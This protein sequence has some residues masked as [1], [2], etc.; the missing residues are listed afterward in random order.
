[1]TRPPLFAPGALTWALG[2]ED[3]C[4]Y[5]SVEGGLQ[6]DEH[7]L[8][9]HSARWRDDLAAARTLGA[10]ALRYGMSWPLVHTGPG[11]FAWDHLDE[12]VDHA[13]NEL[14]LDLVADL[15]HYGTPPWL[16]LSFAD[17]LFPA[18][19]EEFAGALAAR[20]AGRI[21]AYTP[22]NEP[23]TTAS[24][25]G[26]RGVWPPHRLGWDGWVS[27]AVPIAVGMSRATDAIRRADPSALIVHVEASTAVTA[28]ADGASEAALLASVGWLPT[29]LLMG[30]VDAQHPMFAWL[31]AHGADPLALEEVRQRAAV[32][33]LL[34]V[35]YYPDLTPRRLRTVA[36]RRLQVAY[37]GGAAVF[38]DVL[39]GFSARYGLPLAV[40][41]TSIEG[42]D[43]TRAAWV[44]AAVATVSDLRDELDIRALTWWPLFDFVDW[45]WAS[46]GANVEEFAVERVAADGSIVVGFAE[47]LGSPG[48][49]KAPFLRRMGLLRLEE[50][51]DG[52]L[53]RVPTRAAAAFAR[54]AARR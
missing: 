20:Y 53:A 9:E 46:D 5:P 24:F 23:L 3:T 35:N 42:D 19:L 15:V 25:S 49:A 2:I 37:D 54:V 39:R 30:R 28:D 33:D 34:G 45:S 8:T 43:D 6:L 13:T 7:E 27:V 14:G 50:G 41:E 36:G 52:G 17:P 40:T 29:D 47:P 51:R 32:P 10:T 44:R 38:A 22:L 26:L 18:A 31:L 12:V 21:R 16:E 1:V 11:R 48:E 4:V